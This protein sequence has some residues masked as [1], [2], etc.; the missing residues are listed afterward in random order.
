MEAQQRDE[1]RARASEVAADRQAFD[2]FDRSQQELMT[3]NNDSLSCPEQSLRV[4]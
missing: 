1:L 2:F 4:G 3:E